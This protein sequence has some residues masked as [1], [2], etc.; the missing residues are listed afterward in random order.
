MGFHHEKL[1]VSQTR[2][3]L[4]GEGKGKPKKIKRKR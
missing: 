2:Y 1:N 3:S 4:P